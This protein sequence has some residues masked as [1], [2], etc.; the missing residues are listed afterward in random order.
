MESGFTTAKGLLFGEKT[1]RNKSQLVFYVPG[2][3]TS[4]NPINAFQQ[5]LHEEGTRSYNIIGLRCSAC[6]YLELY[7]G[8]P[9]A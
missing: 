4:C 6:G 9:A 8:G 2:T 7:A 3:P 5:G 1:E